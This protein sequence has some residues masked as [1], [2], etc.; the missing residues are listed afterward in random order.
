MELS[1]HLSETG[2]TLSKRMRGYYQEDPWFWTCK[3][4][5]SKDFALITAKWKPNVLVDDEE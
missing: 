1:H 4:Q 3:K 5:R 2:K